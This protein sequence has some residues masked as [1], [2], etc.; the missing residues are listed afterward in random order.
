MAPFPRR[1]LIP[2]DRGLFPGIFP[3]PR[4]VETDLPRGPKELRILFVSDVHLRPAVSQ[5]RLE[6][7]IDRMAAA[8]ANVLLLGGDYA[9]TPQDCRRFFRALSRV[10]FPLGAYAVLGNNDA[11]SRDTLAE[12]ARAAGVTLLVNEAVTLALPE[13]PVQIGGCDEPKYGN[14]Q[15]RALFSAQGAYRILL[16]HFPI[17]P[18][19]TC[20]LMLSGHTHAG[21]CNLWGVTPYAL[22]F[23]RKYRLMAL[24]GAHQL[25]HMHLLVG[26]G[27]G[28]SRIPLRLGAE[29]QIYLLKFSR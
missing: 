23:E 6:A 22:G 11:Q 25:Q 10:R 26:N 1:L 5:A 20:D 9:E 29:P 2:P 16:S 18:D 7:L 12:T 4:L 13:G 27:I 28:I 24:K 15:T 14:P 8:Q 19:C 21:Q 3:Q 17:H